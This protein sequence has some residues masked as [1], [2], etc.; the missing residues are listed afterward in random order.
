MQAK[1]AQL[2]TMAQ[3]TKMATKI[4]PTMT[5]ERSEARYSGPV[6]LTLKIGLAIAKTSKTAVAL[7]IFIE[8]PIQCLIIEIGPIG[9]G[10]HE[11]GV[12]DFV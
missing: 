9:I 10:E 11:L 1:N 8:A 2:P 4:K 5:L 6:E 12:C 7:V 3:G